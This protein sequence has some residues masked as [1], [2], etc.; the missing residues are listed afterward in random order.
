MIP[1][2]RHVFNDFLRAQRHPSSADHGCDAQTHPL[3]AKKDI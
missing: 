3:P 1:S 2:A